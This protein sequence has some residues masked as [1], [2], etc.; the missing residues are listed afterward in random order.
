MT[1]NGR[2]FLMSRLY[3]QSGALIITA[4][5]LSLTGIFLLMQGGSGTGLIIVGGISGVT[6]VVIY[7]RNDV[8]NYSVGNAT[9]ILVL[10]SSLLSLALLIL[11]LLRYE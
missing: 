11:V 2:A 6:G 4:L 1:Q 9:L 10:G 8:E 3:L 5:A 7:F